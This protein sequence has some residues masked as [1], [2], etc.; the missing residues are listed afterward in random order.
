MGE[1][2]EIDKKLLTAA[3]NGD[4]AG[5]QAALK[6]GAN[7]EAKAMFDDT[8][9]NQAA[10]WGHIEVVKALLDAGANVH[11]KGGADKTPIKNAAF[12]GHVEI[13]RLLLEKGAAIDNDLL[14]SVQMKVGILEENAGNGIVTPEAVEAWKTFFAELVARANATK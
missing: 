2:N 1:A 11:N 12:A 7:V 6:G 8:A 9:L 14:M 3:E 5:V 10:Q 13:V 4:L